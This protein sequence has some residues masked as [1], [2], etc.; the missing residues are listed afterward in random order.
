MQIKGNTILITGGGSGIGRG[1][2]EA[3]HKEGNHV[4]IAGRRKE[5]LDAVVAA[6]PGMSAEVLDINSADTIKTFATELIAKYPKLNAVMHNAGIMK[7][8]DVKQGRTEDAE[9]TITT[10]LLGPIRLNAALL[11]HLMQQPSATVMTVT[12]GLA[13]VPLSMTPTYCATKAAI[14]SYTQS[15]RFQLRDTGVQVI[16]IIPPYVQTELMGDRQKNDPMAMPLADYLSDTLNFLRDN[17]DAPEVI[18]D[19]VKPLRFAA[20][21][22]DYD[23]FYKTFNDRMIAARPN[24]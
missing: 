3:F 19:R 12:S 17:P 7:N 9:A 15:L 2:A 21:G 4:I 1:L 16:E 23:I 24:G 22:G 10:N 13:Y 20:Q 5:A 6:N 14:H 18:I 8:E 11:P